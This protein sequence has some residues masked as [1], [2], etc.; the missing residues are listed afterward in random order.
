MRTQT[1]PSLRAKAMSYLA[2]REYS[3]H[4]LRQKL[5]NYLPETTE[6]TPADINAHYEAVDVLLEDFKQ[7]GWLSDA[8]FTEQLIHAK[9][10]KFGSLKIAHEL[11]ENGIAESIVD[12]A[13]ATVEANELANAREIYRKK[14]AAP[15]ANRE[16]WAKHARFLQNRGFAFDVIKRTLNTAF[17]EDA[18]IG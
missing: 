11:R 8:R 7:R 18:D 17:D 2:R 6:E 16:E 1:K 12:D 3:Y 13:L 15:P 10:R 14:F 9:Q 5:R 4:E